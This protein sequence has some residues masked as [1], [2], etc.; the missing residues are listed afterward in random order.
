MS[1]IF[2]LFKKIG[3]TSAAPGGKVTHLL[4]GLGN[5]GAQYAFTRHNTG[6]MAID[7]IAEKCGVKM[8][9]AKYKSLC[10]EG[11]LGARRVLFMKPQTY[12]NLSGEAVAAAADFYK[13]PPENVIVMSDDISFDVGVM[14]LRRSGSAGGH[15][16]L[17]SII[18]CL[19]SENFPRIKIGVGKKPTPE[20]DLADFVLGK[21]SD[22]DKKILFSLFDKVYH[23]A[24]DILLGDMEKAMNL[25]NG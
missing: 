7:F 17:K 24:E 19:G 1:D 22:A 4:V 18:A 14:R 21:Y 25:Y 23:C 10:G 11:E 9:K 3:S 8:E 13:I 12:M 5:P 20:M 6:F 15:N 2:D 16:G